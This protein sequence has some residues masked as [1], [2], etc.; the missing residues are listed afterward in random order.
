[1]FGFSN[2]QL[3]LLSLIINLILLLSTLHGSLDLTTVSKDEL[4]SWSQ[5]A[6]ERLDQFTQQASRHTAANV[7]RAPKCDMCSAAPELCK[8]MG[9][10]RMAQA[11][12]YA[13]SNQRLRRVLKKMR[14]GEPWTLGVIGG[15]G[16]SRFL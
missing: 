11:L 1:M 13:G 15:S 3:L 6:N 5:L 12:S 16:T 7:V 9:K 10:N 8:D 4:H 2:R 14:S